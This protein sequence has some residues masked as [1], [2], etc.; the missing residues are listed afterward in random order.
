MQKDPI[1]ES[2]WNYWEESFKI[3]DDPALPLWMNRAKTV[4]MNPRENPEWPF[5]AA[6]YES[7]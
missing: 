5:F 2:S 3:A 7:S 1:L 6:V 4:Q